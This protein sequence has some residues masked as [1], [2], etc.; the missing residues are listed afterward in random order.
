MVH[1]KCCNNMFKM[2]QLFQSDVVAS[3]S[4]LQ[5]ANVLFECFMLFGRGARLARELADGALGPGGRGCC[6]CGGTGGVLIARM[7]QCEGGRCG[8]S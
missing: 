8:A 3:C 5:V 2:F 6:G 4:M 7:E 1:R